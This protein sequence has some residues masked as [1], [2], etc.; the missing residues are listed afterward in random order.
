MTA[1][2]SL[3]HLPLHII[4]LVKLQK[5]SVR[6]VGSTSLGQSLS[7]GACQPDVGSCRNPTV[8]DAVAQVQLLRELV[9][10]VNRFY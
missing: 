1:V 6:G 7:G 4:I 8:P 9:L 2:L 10:F 3:R 5:P